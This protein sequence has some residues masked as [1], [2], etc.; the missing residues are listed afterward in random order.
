MTTKTKLCQVLG[1]DRKTLNDKLEKGYAL[2]SLAGKGGYDIDKCVKAYIKH[3]S[4]TIR[5]LSRMN[6]RNGIGSKGNSGNS[7]LP[8]PDENGEPDDLNYWRIEKEKEGALKLRMENAQSRGDLI[9]SAALG[10]LS[11]GTL[12]HCKNQLMGISGQAQKRTDT[13]TPDQ[14]KIIDELVIAGLQSL[15]ETKSK[16]ELRRAYRQIIRR[17]AKYYN[18]AREDAD[19][20]LD[21]AASE[22]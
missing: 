7:E 17:Y 10:E 3:Q 6:T 14:L 1:V 12:T 21:R 13:F 18:S 2:V 4:K 5:E 20:S 15:K 22:T 9:P 11:G 8:E 19:T 16:D